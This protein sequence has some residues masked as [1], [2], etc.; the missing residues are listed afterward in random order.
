MRTGSDDDVLRA[1]LRTVVALHRVRVQ[2]TTATADAGHAG[3][4]Q[5][6]LVTGVDVGDIALP[7][8]YQLRPIQRRHCG[9]VKAHLR[10]QTNAFGKIGRQ[11]H[12]LLRHAAD[13]DAGAAQ[14]RRLQHRDFGAMACGA[15]SSRQTTR[16]ATDHRYIV[17]SRAH[18]KRSAQYG[19]GSM[20]GACP[21]IKSAISCPLPL[22]MLMPSMPC[23]AASQT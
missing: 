6:L 8:L 20:A 5:A 3:F 9:H 4:I 19:E 14:R 13:V 10:S 23:P 1:Q 18:W 22:L 11:P 12:R 17:G 7:P 21:V 16:T 2:Q 15:E